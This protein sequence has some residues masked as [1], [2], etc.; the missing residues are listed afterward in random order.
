[1]AWLGEAEAWD[2][3]SKICSNEIKSNAK[4]LF[5]SDDSAYVLNCLGQNIF[6]SLKDRNIYSSSPLGELLINEYAEYSKLSILKYL[7]HSRDLPFSGKM[8]PP[9][10]LPGGDIFIKGTHVFPLDT[11]AEYFENNT[12]EFIKAGKNLAGTQ[13]EYGDMS[14]KL[15]PFPRVPV[16]IIIWVGD[17]EFPPKSTLLLDSSC[18]S[19]IPTEIIW[20]TA[21]MS[22]KMIL[23]EK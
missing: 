23:T 14:I 20:S 16:F 10:Y 5:N 3:L 18:I 4:V 19:Q 8:I 17:E 15:L 12:K 21:M 2:E 22:I 1:M 7:I 6:V 9:S 11:V 13:L